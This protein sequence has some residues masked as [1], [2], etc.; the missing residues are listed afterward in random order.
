MTWKLD[1]TS[2]GS[3]R[4]PMR[5]SSHGDPETI[6]SFPMAV[7]LAWACCLWFL[8]YASCNCLVVKGE[9][10]EN[11]ARKSRECG[12][13][14]FLSALSKPACGPQGQLPAWLQRLELD[15]SLPGWGGSSLGTGDA[16]AGTYA[17]LAAPAPG[18][19]GR[20]RGELLGKD[21][22]KAGEG[23]EEKGVNLS[24]LLVC[25]LLIPYQALEKC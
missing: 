15:R 18:M 19:G 14:H 16:A 11:G 7:S 2:Q 6:T 24:W 8:P 17:G 3:F 13:W 5:K 9:E 25:C 20:G 4:K 22:A 1:G 12:P 21:V 23:K 10:D